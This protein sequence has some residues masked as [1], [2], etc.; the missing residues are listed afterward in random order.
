MNAETS[1]WA[2]SSPTSRRTWRILRNWWQQQVTTFEMWVFIVNSLSRWTPRSRTD[3][4][5]RITVV[6]VSSVRSESV[7]FASI[8][9][10]PNHISSV[11]AALSCSLRDA[12]HEVMSLIQLSSVWRASEWHI[13]GRYAHIGLL[14]VSNDDWL[15]DCQKSTWRLLC[16]KWRALGP[17]RSLAGC[18]RWLISVQTSHHWHRTSESGLTSKMKT[19][20]RRWCVVQ[21]VYLAPFLWYFV[22]DYL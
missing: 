16:M 13:I 7:S 17:A 21:R 8:W 18:C 2:T 12:H 22:H 10:E 14:V 9:R 1:C 20:I 11:L 3:F 15:D 4:E 6:P 5:G 19:N